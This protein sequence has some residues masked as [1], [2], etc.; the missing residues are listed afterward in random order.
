MDHKK[1]QRIYATIDK[2]LLYAFLQ[3]EHLT[4]TGVAKALGITQQGFYYHSTKN[5]LPI[6]YIYKISEMTNIPIKSLTFIDDP[7]IK[8]LTSVPEEPDECSQ[9]LY[10]L[11]GDPKV[12]T[13]G[14]AQNTPK[15]DLFK[16][17]PKY[18][19]M[20]APKKE[21]DIDDLIEKLRTKLEERC[22]EAKYLDAKITYLR[23]QIDWLI[24]IN[25]V[26]KRNVTDL[27]DII[28]KDSTKMEDTLW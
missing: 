6:S 15:K 28:E 13:Y 25:S 23:A 16:D 4:V 12:K 21:I 20:P 17:Q 26:K 18:V 24:V 10:V 9:M 7:A 8:S 19:T 1:Q 14:W 22:V 5:V 3:E 27:N 11:R 2:E